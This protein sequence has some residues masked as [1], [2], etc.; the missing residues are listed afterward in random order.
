MKLR[1]ANTLF[2][3]FAGAGMVF[4]V[5]AASFSTVSG[6]EQ[7]SPQRQPAQIWIDYPLE[8][9]VF[10]PEITSPTFLWHDAGNT[11]RRWV[12]EV[13]FADDSNSIR[14]DVPGERFHPGEADPNAGPGLAMT[15]EQA[16]AL[17]WTP[18]ADTWIKIKRHS[19]ASPVCISIQGFADSDSEVPIAVAKV[20]IS[21]STD[22]VGAPVF[23]RDVP[24]MLPSPDEKGPIAPLP[25]SAIPL[26]A[27]RGS[28]CPTCR[29]S[30]VNG[31]TPRLHS[32]PAWLTVTV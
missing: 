1:L 24:L 30:A 11:S 6:T 14:I 22:P 25:R 27:S 26:R 28:R 21:T 16:S 29:V 10:P 3:A 32:T 8:G 7:A 13:K 15:E 18:D 5:C 19:V 20:S 4:L 31:V 2:A 12:I 23:Y 17:T 9:T